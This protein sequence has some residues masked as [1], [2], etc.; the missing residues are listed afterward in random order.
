[1]SLGVDLRLT[2]SKP[3]KEDDVLRTLLKMKP[4]PFTPKTKNKKK[5]AKDD[6]RPNK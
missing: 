2:M 5:V 3:P 6:P 1:M 4:E